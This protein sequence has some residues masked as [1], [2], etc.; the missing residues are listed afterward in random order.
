MGVVESAWEVYESI[1]EREF[2]EINF[3]PI[4]VWVIFYV[5]DSGNPLKLP[6]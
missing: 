6:L 1:F 5:Y 3:P 2:K 4:I